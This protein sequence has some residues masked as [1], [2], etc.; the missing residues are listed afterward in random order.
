MC[1]ENTPVWLR[2]KNST[3]HFFVRTLLCVLNVK[4]PPSTDLPFSSTRPA[5]VWR[6]HDITG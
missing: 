5:E 6:K 4:Q 3:L 1:G 2:Y